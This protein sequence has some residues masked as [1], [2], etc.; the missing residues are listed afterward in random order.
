MHWT[1]GLFTHGWSKRGGAEVLWAVD[2]STHWLP[3]SHWYSDHQTTCRRRSWFVGK[4]EMEKF[5]SLP[6]TALFLLLFRMSTK[7]GQIMTLKQPFW[8]ALIFLAPSSCW[9][10]WWKEKAAITWLQ[11]YQVPSSSSC[12]Y[13]SSDQNHFFCSFSP[14]WDVESQSWSHEALASRTV[15]II[16]LETDGGQHQPLRHSTSGEWQAGLLKQV[17]IGQQVVT[18]FSP[19]RSQWVPLE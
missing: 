19:I 5:N 4:T 2:E 7:T 18:F 11:T 6:T 17:C 16:A 8:I 1:F 13:V 10:S 3:N 12:A 14:A 9:A 15:F